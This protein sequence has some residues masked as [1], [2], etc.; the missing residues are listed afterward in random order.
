MFDLIPD[1]IEI[2][3]DILNPIQTSAGKMA[4][5]AELKR[6]YGDKLTFCGAVDTQRI[7]PHGTP[8]Q[9]REEVRR[10]IEVLAPGGGYMLSS[11]HTIMNEVPPE[12][13]LAMVD[14]AVEFG[15]YKH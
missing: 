2:G 5:L 6:Q 15:Q 9:V 10:V 8:A 13:I 7:L 11:V 4:N 14:A 3:V 1:L 12:N